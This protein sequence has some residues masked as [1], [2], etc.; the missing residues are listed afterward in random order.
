MH[1]TVGRTPSQGR[2]QGVVDG[3]TRPGPHQEGL[4][5]AER[6][7]RAC[8]TALIGDY[9][10]EGHVPLD[11]IQKMLK[12][13][14]KIAAL[15]VAGMPIGT[16]GKESGAQKDPYDV[17]AFDR[18]GPQTTPVSQKVGRRYINLPSG[19]RSRLSPRGQAELASDVADCFFE[20][21]SAPS[22][23]ASTSL[24]RQRLLLHAADRLTLHQPAQELDDRQHELR[25]RLLHFVWFG[26]PSHRRGA[27]ARRRRALLPDRD[28]LASASASRSRRLSARSSAAVTGAA[29]TVRSRS[30]ACARRLALGFF[31]SAS[32]RPRGAGACAVR[33][34][35]A[36]AVTVPAGRDPRRRAAPTGAGR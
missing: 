15:G 32:L 17:V 33:A 26:I 9:V 1:P 7:S 13:R 12:E 25:D 6:P 23:T 8:H 27:F 21:S 36:G 19:P 14:P 24:R 29:A 30:G 11:A 34:W 31:T 22:P 16:P 35:R 2:L 3:S 18:N 5:R 28:G 10:V 20:L 4:R